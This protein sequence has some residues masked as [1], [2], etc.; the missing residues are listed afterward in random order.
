MKMKKGNTKSECKGEPETS[1]MGYSRNLF[2]ESNY[3][4]IYCGKY[5]GGSFEDWMQ[6][7]REHVIPNSKLVGDDAKYKN[8]H[9]NFR[10][11]WAICNNMR[12]RSSFPEYDGL[13]IDERIEKTLEA[14]K[15]LILK[16]REEFERFYEMC[17]KS[18]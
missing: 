14:K 17:V 11:A 7:T 15:K 4:C 9:K 6:L 16:R 5:F 10:V 12:T 8:Y 13:P 2:K 18:K 3:T 1:L